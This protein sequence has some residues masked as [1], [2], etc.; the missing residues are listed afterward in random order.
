M[1]RG[2]KNPSPATRFSSERQPEN[3]RKPDPILAALKAKMT[4]ER[5]DAIAE[6]LLLKMETGDIAALN[7]GWERLAGK[8]PNKNEQGGPGDF[9]EE[10]SDED[11]TK[12]RAALKV[13]RGRSSSR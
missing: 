6:A 11:R 10:L 5:A 7:S 2:N 1:A 12:I 8:V 13:V 4:P 9:D 3:R